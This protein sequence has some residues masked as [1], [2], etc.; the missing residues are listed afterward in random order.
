MCQWLVA[1]IALIGAFFLTPSIGLAQNASPR[2]WELF[3]AGGASAVVPD[4]SV[5]SILMVGLGNQTVVSDQ[6]IKTH[7]HPSGRLLAGLRLWLTEHDGLEASYSYAPSNLTATDTITQTIS[8]GTATF[9]FSSPASARAHFYSFNY[10]R[11]FRSRGRWRPYLTA[12]IGGIHW[13]AATGGQFHSGL[14]NGFTGNFGAGVD[15]TFSPHWALQ[16][17]YRDYLVG[18][19]RFTLLEPGGLSHAQSPTVGLV[20]RF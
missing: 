10:V 8:S 20:F 11:R 16:A 5:E 12:G 1:S 2:R 9:L 17:E 19:L 13:E 3:V 4:E 18:H 7:V 15:W 6:I 14:D